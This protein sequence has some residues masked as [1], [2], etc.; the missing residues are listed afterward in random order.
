MRLIASAVLLLG[1]SNLLCA[2]VPKGNVFAGYSFMSTDLPNSAQ[3]Q[4]LNG[5][6]ASL[7]GKVLPFLGI[8]A[9]GSGHYGTT[10]VPVCPSAVGFSC[11]PVRGNVYTA[12][13]GPRLSASVHGIRPFAHVLIGLGAISG[14]GSDVSLASAYG[15]GLD[16]KIAPIIGW[17][18]QGDYVHTHFAGNSQGHGRLS[19]GI[20]LRF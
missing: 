12:M 13:F 1:F 7:E 16:F 20:V 19:T 8:V 18:F 3:R 10:E 15:G 11:S 5:W 14:V 2:Q 4:N 9:D 17:R 6:E